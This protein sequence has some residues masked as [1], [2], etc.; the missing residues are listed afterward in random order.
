MF[1][2]KETERFKKLSKRKQ[3]IITLLPTLLSGIPL[4]LLLISLGVNS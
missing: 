3:K 1:E 2:L 4:V